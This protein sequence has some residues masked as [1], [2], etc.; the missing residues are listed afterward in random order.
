MKKIFFIV[1]VLSFLLT[2]CLKP[3]EEN[4]YRKGNV[5]F[6]HPDGCGL[7]TWHALRILT[8]G[9]DGELN[10]D[11][12][13]NIGLY[14]SHTLNSLTTSSN[15]GATM[16]AYGK[17]V[18]Y[19]SYGM[20]GFEELTALSGKNKSIMIEAK[21]AGIHVGIINSGE[22][23][24]PGT[25]VFVSSAE[26]RGNFELITEEIIKSGADVI[27]SG[28]ENWMLPEG[29]E[30]KFGIGLRKDGQNLIEYA[31]Q[32][33]YYVIYNKDEL[34]QIPG[35]AQKLLGVFAYMHTFNDKSEEELKELGLPN[36]FDYA[37]TVAEMTEAALD[38][39]SNKGGRFF[40]VV[41][42]EGTDNFANYNNANGT[43][44]ALERAD[45]AIGAALKYYEKN[46]NTLILVASDSE[47][48]G[49]ELI[50]FPGNNFNPGEPLPAKE[51]NGAPIDGIEG[52]ESLCFWSAP[53][54]FGNRLPF[55]VAWST[56][57][58]TYGSV[59]ARAIGLNG[60]LLNGNVDNTDMYRIMY[61][62]LF[63]KYRK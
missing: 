20:N 32:N 48:G 51:S 54:Q 42:E 49:M 6:I 9:P 36:Y 53:D 3:V 10:W 15:A 62:T 39:F 12:L 24:E 22:M 18:V 44:E 11:K 23:V 19:N 46:Q 40:L 63:G 35:D 33:G 43:F 34:K 31:K 14:K 8:K 5:I 58:D 38:F 45:K 56:N 1:V 30:G 7:A 41:E 55:R 47:A 50:G 52:S 57:H 21:D 4:T 26:S 13:P 2:S 28:G 16:H 60:E 29:V 17:K 59:V 37:P 61:A 27:M 25:G